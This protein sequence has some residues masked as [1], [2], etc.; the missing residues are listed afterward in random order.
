MTYVCCLQQGADCFTFLYTPN[1]D[2]SIDSIVAAIRGNNVPLIPETG[3]LGLGS[4]AEVLLCY[5]HCHTCYV[6]QR[7]LTIAQTP[8]EWH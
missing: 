1:N 3:T 5:T 4:M 7:M 2:T 8:A 6:S